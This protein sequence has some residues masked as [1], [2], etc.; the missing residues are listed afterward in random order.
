MLT[1]I[2]KASASLLV[3]NPFFGLWLLGAEKIYNDSIPTAALVLSLN[4]YRLKYWFNQDFFDNKLNHKQRIFVLAHEVMHDCLLHH[5][6]PEFEDKYIANLAQDMYINQ[7]LKKTLVTDLYETPEGLILPSTFP[8]LKLPDNETD[9]FYYKELMKAKTKK[10]NEDKSN[11]KGTSG[12]KVF[13]EYLENQELLGIWKHIEQQ[14]Y[15]K[16]QKDLAKA[17][18]DSNL[19]EVANKASGKSIGN[20]PASIESY[21]KALSEP[22]FVPWNRV[23]RNMVGNVLS[24]IVEETRRRPNK[25]F[26]MFS[27]T[28]QVP[29]L[30]I[31]LGIDVS[32]SISDRDFLEFNNEIKSIAKE[33][34]VLCFQWDVECSEP[35]KYKDTFEI[36]RLKSGGTNASCFIEEV[37][38]SKYDFDFIIIFTDGYIE[39][40]PIKSNRPGLW[41]IT[42]DGNMNIN[43]KLPK[44]QINYKK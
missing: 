8:G 29:K 23:L 42:S 27:G 28:R 14:V 11:K 30:K 41:V 16:A 6:R 2:E 4:N 13:D 24:D 10:E 35:Y 26:D 19:K 43:H 44:I 32:G 37:N 25:R 1:N 40:T 33:A 39:N 38:K 7:E 20:L 17:R 34:E 21:L 12:C 3:R 36:Q 18:A 15:S 5:F 9:I 22:P 31:G